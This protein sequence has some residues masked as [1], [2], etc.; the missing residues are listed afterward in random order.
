MKEGRTQINHLAT[1]WY[2]DV[3]AVPSESDS[4]DEAETSLINQ[5]AEVNHHWMQSYKSRVNHLGGNL[6]V[7]L[8]FITY[9]KASIHI[10]KLCHADPLSDRMYRVL[11]VC[12]CT[13]DSICCLYTLY[14]VQCSRQCTYYLYMFVFVQSKQ[15]VETVLINTK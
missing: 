15:P 2:Q 5:T 9:P 14:N 12:T 7:C 1:Q 11:V 8:S 6:E 10:S 13:L 3:R 4:E